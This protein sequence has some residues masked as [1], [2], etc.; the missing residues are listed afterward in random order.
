MKKN[1]N[2]TAIIII[3][4]SSELHFQITEPL[5]VYSLNLRKNKRLQGAFLSVTKWMK[6]KEMK[7]EHKEHT[8]ILRT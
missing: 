8:S 7:S 1:N 6:F 4:I 5:Y 3:I 2:N